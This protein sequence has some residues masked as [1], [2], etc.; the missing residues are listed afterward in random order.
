MLYL[1]VFQGKKYTKKMMPY[2]TGEVGVV[3]QTN[4]VKH[5]KGE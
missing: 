4:M 3:H 2:K 5:W 1:C